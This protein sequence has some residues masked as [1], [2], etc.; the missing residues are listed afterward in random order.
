LRRLQ[1]LPPI[2]FAEQLETA[3]ECTFCSEA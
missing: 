2:P 3:P 1:S